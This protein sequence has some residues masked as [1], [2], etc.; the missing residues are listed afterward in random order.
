MNRCPLKSKKF[1]PEIEKHFKFKTQKNYSGNLFFEIKK[2]QIINEESN[3]FVIWCKVVVSVDKDSEE[4]NKL[5]GEFY[6]DNN[7]KYIKWKDFSNK[8]DISG[9]IENSSYDGESIGYEDF[10]E[11]NSDIV[12]DSFENFLLYIQKYQLNQND[13]NL[14]ENGIPKITEDETRMVEIGNLT[15]EYNL[16][17]LK[18]YCEEEVGYDFDEVDELNDIIELYPSPDFAADII[19]CLFPEKYVTIGQ[20]VYYGTFEYKGSNE[21][22]IKEYTAFGKKIDDSKYYVGGQYN[23]D[24]NKEVS[25]EL[26]NKLYDE[27]IIEQEP[28]YQQFYFLE[29]KNFSSLENCLDGDFH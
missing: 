27:G 5:I 8:I 14:I 6:L 26:F 7:S 28:K 1:K 9:I 15:F 2:N 21:E 25:E 19:E 12:T 20:Y 17:K 11:L 29:K 4:S 3:Y 10:K 24:R 23:E 13:L 22:D 16:K 18:E